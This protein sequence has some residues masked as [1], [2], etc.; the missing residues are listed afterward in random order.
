MCSDVLELPL[1]VPDLW[2]NLLKL[3]KVARPQFY[4]RL[5]CFAMSFR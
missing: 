3:V 1:L 2:E 4:N 5:D